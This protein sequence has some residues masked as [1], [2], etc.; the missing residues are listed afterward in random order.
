MISMIYAEET[1]F[2]KINRKEQTMNNKTSSLLSHLSSLKRKTNSHFTLLELLIV[3]AIIAILAGI[4]MP[5]LSSALRKAKIISCTG[6]QKSIGLALSMYATDNKEFFPHSDYTSTTYLLGAHYWH[7]ALLMGGYMGKSLTEGQAADNNKR[8]KN[9]LICPEDTNPKSKDSSPD[10]PRDFRSY[11]LSS[12]I[13][14]SK[15]STTYNEDYYHYISRNRLVVGASCGKTGCRN[16]NG[17]IRK[18]PQDIFIT[19]DATSRLNFWAYPNNSN[20]DPENPRCM[21]PPRHVTGVPITFVDGHVN[22]WSYPFPT[23]ALNFESTT[24]R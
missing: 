24:R 13:A 9:V 15:E 8:G 3:V 2:C 23:E 14:A 4:L 10:K 1:V 11:G 6:N 5:A 17:T 12:S 19:T 7:R 20:L 18:G 21:I 16:G 22:F